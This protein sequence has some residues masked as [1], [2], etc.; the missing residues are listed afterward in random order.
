MLEPAG[1]DVSVFFSF[2]SFCLLST[3]TLLA[4]ALL[5]EAHLQIAVAL[6][7]CQRL[8]P[9]G[10]TVSAAVCMVTGADARASVAMQARLCCIALLLDHGLAAGL[11]QAALRWQGQ[12]T[13]IDEVECLVANLIARNLVKGYISH[14]MRTAVLSKVDAFPAAADHPPAGSL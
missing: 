4:G 11:L 6:Q 3:G 7:Q 8:Q 13:D 5:T 10:S 2:F 12:D 1:L 14:N 9:S